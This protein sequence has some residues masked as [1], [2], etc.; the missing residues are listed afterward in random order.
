MGK[1]NTYS[2]IYCMDDNWVNRLSLGHSVERKHLTS[3]LEVQYLQLFRESM[4]DVI[5]SHCWTSKW[6]KYQNATSQNTRTCPSH[7]FNIVISNTYK[8]NVIIPPTAQTGG[9]NTGIN[10]F[11]LS[12]CPGSL[13]TVRCHYKVVSFL[14]IPHNRHGIACLLGRDMCCL[15]W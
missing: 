9:G 12:I 3:I 6:S 13:C 15:L 8:H 10:L 11:S 1:L 14:Q 5:F 2:P 4:L 7:A